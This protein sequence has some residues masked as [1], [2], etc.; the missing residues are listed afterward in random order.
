MEQ[1]KV[2]DFV[3]NYTFRSEISTQVWFKISSFSFKDIYHKCFKYIY[4]CLTTLIICSM[5]H[6]ER[7]NY[8]MCIVCYQKAYEAH[9]LFKGIICCVKENTN[10]CRIAHVNM[11]ITFGARARHQKL[12]RQ[13]SLVLFVGTK[14][15]WTF[16][17]S[18]RV[19]S[20]DIF[21]SVFHNW[22]VL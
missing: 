9:L 7:W 1:K 18:D 21:V 12:M 4:H 22:T 6:Q 2:D 3:A 15:H 17:V 10:F 5:C 20:K 14:C 16:L 13:E 19:K 8:N 11:P